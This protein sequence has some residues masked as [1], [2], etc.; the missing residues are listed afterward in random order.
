M[1]NAERLPLKAL[2]LTVSMAA[3][4]LSACVL[5]PTTDPGLE[6]VIK[7]HYAK[8]ATEE[9]GECRSP[10]IDTIQSHEVKGK[11]EDGGE[12]MTIRYG[13]FDPNA[14]MDANWSALFH[15]AQH[16]GG[17]AE[18]NFSLIRTKLGYRV[19][20]MAGEQREV[21]HTD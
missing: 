19:T 14:D 7:A 6:R 21:G 20:D 16:C 10:R 1:P 4:A 11:S 12:I 13:Y 2:S 9:D 5:G 15:Y 8:H 3:L 17:I 18:R